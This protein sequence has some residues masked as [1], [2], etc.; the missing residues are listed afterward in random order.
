[1]TRAM[2]V[3]L[4]LACWLPAFGLIRLPRALDRLHCATLL[5]VAGGGALLLAAGCAD[6]ASVRVGKIAL[7]LAASLGGGAASSHAI[8][9]A[10]FLRGSADEP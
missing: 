3:L 2:L 10:L 4:V 9:R 5:A 6:G 1:V 8:G 7:L